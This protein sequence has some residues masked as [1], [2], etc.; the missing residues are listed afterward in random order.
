M[1]L[2]SVKSCRHIEI[3]MKLLK[4]KGFEKNWWLGNDAVKHGKVVVILKFLWNY[5]KIK[6]LKKIE[7]LVMMLLSVEKL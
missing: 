1:I 3:F 5:W 4:N 7:G 6:V 2:L